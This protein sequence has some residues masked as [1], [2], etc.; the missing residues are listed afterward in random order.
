[1]FSFDSLV[2]VEADSISSYLREC[3]RILSPDGAAFIHHSNVGIYRRSG[4]WLDLAAK[5]ARAI[6]VSKKAVLGSAEPPPWHH[7]RG[8]SMTA[9]RFVTMT[10]EAG[11][12]CPGQEVIAWS[13][14]LLTDC[15]SVVT[16][17]GS[18]WDRPY[19][20][21]QNR[22]FPAAARSSKAAVH[23]FQI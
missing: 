5:T 20:F 14:P 8:R 18:R 1:V 12:V 19:T 10:N 4:W 3:A 11:L 13:T 22:S 7:N 17:K 2:H 15:I 21:S 16:R 6:P 23:A 9:E